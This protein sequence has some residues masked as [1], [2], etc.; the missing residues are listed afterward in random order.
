MALDDPSKKMSKSAISEHSYISLLDYPDAIRHKIKIA[1][2]DS[3]TA[4]KYDPVKKPAISNLLNIY[5]G[6]SAKS[7]QDLEKKY[8]DKSYAEFKKDLA[9]VIIEGLSHLQHKFNELSID[10]DVVLEILRKGAG[11]ATEISSQTLQEVKEKMG[12][13]V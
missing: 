11:K 5:S 6:F 8:A 3:E 2:T 12:F 13:L 7:I 10:K 9:E 4:V 1:V